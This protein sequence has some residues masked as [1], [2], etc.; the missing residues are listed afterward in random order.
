[1]TDDQLERKRAYDRERQAQ[2]R[3]EPETRPALLE[4]DK[5][6][7]RAERAAQGKP[8][9]AQL[10]SYMATYVIKEPTP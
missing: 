4:R 5:L 2:I 3:R 8:Y 10:E 9:Q 7:K 6:R 1:M